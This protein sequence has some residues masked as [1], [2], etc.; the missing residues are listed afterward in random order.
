MARD[1]A[2]SEDAAAA[3]RRDPPVVGS[4]ESPATLPGAASD[5]Q[6]TEAQRGRRKGCEAQGGASRTRGAAGHDC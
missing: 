2:V 1:F 6:Q 5:P 4:R 3:A